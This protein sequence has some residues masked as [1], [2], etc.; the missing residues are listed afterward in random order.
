MRR[1]VIID[2]VTRA[3]NQGRIEVVI[4]G[5]R[6]VDCRSS[7][8]FFRGFEVML[9]G[10]DPRDAPYFTERIC[11][12]C[13][14]AHATAAAFALENLAGVRPP[15][16]GNILR[17]LILA[18]D[19]LQNHIRHFYVLAVPDYV[20]M[21]EKPP[22]TPR[23]RRGYRLPAG[24]NARMIEHYF[25]ALDVS[26]AAHEMVTALGGKAPFGHGIVAGGA[27][28]PPDAAVVLE[29]RSRLGKIREF[30][31]GKMLPDAHAIAEAYPEYFELGKR[32]VRLLQFGLFPADPERR[33]FHFP[34]MVVEEDR[35]REVDAASITEHVRHAYFEENGAPRAPGFA[36]P[37]PRP[38]KPG[39]HSW[40][41][42]PRYE[43]KAFEGGPL[44]RL[45]ITGRYRRGVSAMD[46]ILARAYE[47]D[48]LCN[49][50]EQW[51]EELEPDRPVFIPFEV[52]KEGEGLGLTGSMRGNLLHFMRVERGRISRYDIITPSAW[53]FSPRD[54][55]GRPGPVEEALLGTPVETPEEPVEVGRIVRSFDPCY[56]CATHVMVGGRKVREFIV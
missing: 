8:F 13:S 4:E 6:V 24:V 33:E 35:S 10:R 43:G 29:L 22:F 3:N 15:R 17:N 20:A 9:E 12:I 40:I 55:L 32:S 44:A 18:A 49:L 51:L 42:A 21:P 34:G 27:T 11:G 7:C 46:R 16:N 19:T 14:A 38:G 2:P 41:K 47:T 23:Y 31:R 45:W 1:T 30:V 53:H 28:V 48:L 39:G 54:D 50:M 26:R 36:R 52:P 25:A 37:E 56:A 5:G